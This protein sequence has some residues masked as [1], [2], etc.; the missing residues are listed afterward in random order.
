MVIK[1]MKHTEI[2]EIPKD[3]D[4]KSIVSLVDKNYG[5]KIGPFG[6]QLKKELLTK[7][8]YKV[9]GQEN[10]Y[11]NNVAIG[12]RYISPE[13]YKKLISCQLKSGDFVISMMGTIGKCMIMPEKHEQ[14]IMD[15]HLIR[16]RLNND[17]VYPKLL[18]HLFS[19]EII[20]K[21]VKKLSVGGIMDGLSSKIIK[22]LELPLAAS[23]TEQTTIAQVLSDIDIAVSVLEKLIA[24][25]KAIRTGSIQRLLK[26][27]RNWIEYNLG[28]DASLKARIGWQGLTKLEYKNTGDFYLVTG[29]DF[30][31][32][33]VDWGN[34]VYVD[35]S[36]YSQDK[37]IQLKINDVLVTKDGTIGKVALV[38]ELK[39]P[40]TLNS[41]IFVIRPINN[42]FDPKFLF[43]ILSSK[44]FKDFLDQLS[45]GSTINHLYQKDFVNF[46]FFAPKEIKE[47]QCIAQILSDMDEEILALE[48]KLKK[49]KQLKQSMMQILLIGKIRLL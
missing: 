4:V 41:G 14:G 24:K 11:E 31:S 46:K 26:P 20:L 42:S 35:E 28:K 8:G 29:T 45:A 16:L 12:K 30:S 3:W 27:K 32:G 33:N 5:I 13:H 23:I 6:S 1:G 18:L 10:I 47:Q 37:N 19:S 38:R 22:Q 25:K 39:K 44:I 48:A 7:K 49:Q 9:Y 36:R 43:Y 15:S 34:C 17:A 21:Q 40:T 2:G